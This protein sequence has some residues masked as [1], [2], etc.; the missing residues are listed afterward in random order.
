[1]SDQELEPG[2]YDA[3]P[4]FAV[5]FTFRIPDEGW[6]SAHMHEEFF[7]VMRFDGPDP[8]VPTHWVAWGFPET[9]HGPEGSQ[10]AGDLSVAEAI[11]LMSRV[12]NV[13]A[14]QPV[15]FT[16]AGF[17]GVQVDLR[18]DT[19][20][21]QI[22]GGEAG[23]LALDPAFEVRLGAI[24]REPGLLLVMCFGR[25]TELDEACAETQPILDSVV[26]R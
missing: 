19:A 15:P 24:P 3:S 16:F 17:D 2:V 18:T 13:E 23:D 9:I 8:A 11:D 7:D 5:D 22:F 1:V 26:L 14:T 4:P 21:T 25:A 20:M 6:E 10:P 12:P